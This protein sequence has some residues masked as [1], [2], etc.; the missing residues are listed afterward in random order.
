M[1]SYR[2]MQ[3]FG[4]ATVAVVAIFGVF[5][6]IREF[7]DFGSLV[8]LIAFLIVFFTLQDD[9]QKSPRY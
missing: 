2:A 3:T 6:I 8:G 7:G 5:S 1:I 9:W 4:R